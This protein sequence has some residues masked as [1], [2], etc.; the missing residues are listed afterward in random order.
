M[1]SWKDVEI[2]FNPIQHFK[3]PNAFS[4]EVNVV[5]FTDILLPLLFVM[6]KSLLSVINAPLEDKD[7]FIDKF[8]P[9]QSKLHSEAYNE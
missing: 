6:R 9:L 7:V 8:L 2:V 1:L 3:R 4:H 5:E